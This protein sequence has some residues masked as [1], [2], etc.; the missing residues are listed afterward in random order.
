[1]IINNIIEFS[2]NNILNTLYVKIIF[3]LK[4][5]KKINDIIKI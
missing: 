3:F 1:M 2:K 4:K 5:K